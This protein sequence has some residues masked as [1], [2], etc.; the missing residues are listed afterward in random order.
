VAQPQ[1]GLTAHLL[2]APL[3]WIPVFNAFRLYALHRIS[4]PEEFR[5]IISAVSVGV[6]LL[7]LGGLWWHPMI[8]RA[9]VPMTWVFGLLLELIARRLWRWRLYRLRRDRGLRF[10]TLIVGADGEA[11]RLADALRSPKLGFQVLGAVSVPGGTRDSDGLVVLGSLDDLTGLMREYGAECLFVASSALGP[12]QMRVVAEAASREG[13][14][15]GVAANL[16]QVLYTRLSIQPLGEAF[17]ISVRPANLSS[18]QTTLKRTF[19]IVAASVLV[20]I[21]APIWLI[22]AL[23][24]GLSSKGSALF[25]QPRVTMGGRVFTMYKFR[26]MRADADEILTRLGIDHS[27]PFFK[28]VDDPRPTR[29]GRTLRRFSLDELPQLINVLKGEMSLV[30]PRPLPAEQVEANPDLG[31]RHQVRAGM[32]GWWQING[33]SRLSPEEAVRMDMFYV[34][35]WSLSF[36]LYILAKTVGAVVNGRGAY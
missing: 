7:A 21:T 25:R 31:P 9:S 34:E 12:E 26:T 8:S 10:R 3:V 4:A 13:T 6:V 1:A 28:L 17:A 22:A 32:T 18:T 5:R 14:E 2:I 16:P 36:D 20:V 19:D 30:G 29:V 24:V 35:N 33:R 15:L 27:A 11:A 23:A